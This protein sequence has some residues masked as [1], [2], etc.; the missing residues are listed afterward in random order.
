MFKFVI[1]GYYLIVFP[2]SVFSMDTLEKHTESHKIK[3]FALCEFAFNNNKLNDEIAY[4]FVNNDSDLFVKKIVDIFSR[5]GENLKNLAAYIENEY[6]LDSILFNVNS[7]NSL[8]KYSKHFKVEGKFNLKAYDYSNPKLNE[9]SVAFLWGYMLFHHPYLKRNE[10]INFLNTNS[11]IICKI[12]NEKDYHKEVNHFIRNI[13]DLHTTYESASYNKYFNITDFPKVRVKKIKSN[14]YITQ[15][16]ID[17]LKRHEFSR[18]EEIDGIRISFVED[19]FKKLYPISESGMLQKLINFV[20][21]SGKKGSY[22][23]LKCIDKN[24]KVNFVR[25]CRD[26]NLIIPNYKQE[27]E[28]I[29]NPSYLYFD[30]VNIEK[31]VDYLKFKKVLKER[32]VNNVIVDLRGHIDYYPP[33]KLLGLFKTNE[34]RLDSI[35]YKEPVK[36]LPGLFKYFPMKIDYLKFKTN[37][38]KLIVLVD[39]STI[40]S[41][42]L[43]LYELKA[44]GAIIIGDTTSGACGYVGYLKM[45]DNA[46]IRYT[47]WGF[48]SSYYKNVFQIGIPPDITYEIKLL[49]Y[50]NHLDGMLNFSIQYFEKIKNF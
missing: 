24:D 45:P 33:R 38:I 13:N 17:S 32:T 9:Y 5:D 39:E 42:E 3:L 47:S 34:S 50:I 21:L 46:M 14:Y 25:F 4:L 19:S 1:L 29:R 44:L 11:S 41:S 20:I 30:F 28:E 15:I 37:N 40:S 8:V 27:S 31:Q 6:K 48:E 43:L 10:W 7:V 36:K 23:T 2:I 16:G 18:I 35:I 12:G 22:F 49:D 26:T